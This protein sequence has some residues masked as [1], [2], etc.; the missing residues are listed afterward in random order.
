MADDRVRIIQVRTAVGNFTAVVE[1]QN[2]EKE[3]AL[4]S[5][6]NRGSPV[7][8]SPPH[9][10]TNRIIYT[11]REKVKIQCI[12]M[13]FTQADTAGDA[14]TIV[15]DGQNGLLRPELLEILRYGGAEDRMRMVLDKAW[16]MTNA[17][18]SQAYAHT[19]QGSGPRPDHP[20]TSF[21]LQSCL[22]C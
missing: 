1:L 5:T 19:R 4:G 22:Y 14:C 21:V 16:V 7:D 9:R 12:H 10:I 13:L 18:S 2:G 17:C 8:K 15:G 3:V 20:T 11:M 6:S